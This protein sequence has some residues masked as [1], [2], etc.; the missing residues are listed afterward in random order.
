MDPLDAANATYSADDFGAIVDDV[1]LLYASEKE[2]S[3]S[4][5]HR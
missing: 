5:S 3:D 2:E 4:D 1:L